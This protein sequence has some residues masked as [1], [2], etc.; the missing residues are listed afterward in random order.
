MTLEL[1]TIPCRSDNYAYLLHD[2]GSGAASQLF[3]Y[4]V[5][6]VKATDLAE[7]LTDIFSGS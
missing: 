1:V 5:K 3:V 2:R 4:Y 6:N 7:K